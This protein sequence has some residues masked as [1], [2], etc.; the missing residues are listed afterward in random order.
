MITII[1]E[2]ILK[3]AYLTAMESNLVQTI[4]SKAN[5]IVDFAKK[6][7]SKTINY[8]TAGSSKRIPFTG[9]ESSCS[10][11]EQDMKETL[12]EDK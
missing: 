5:F 6:V 12:K 8:S 10:R 11:M 3:M 2:D 1:T 7:Y 9:R 4:P